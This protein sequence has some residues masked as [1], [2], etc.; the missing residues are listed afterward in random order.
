MINSF[1]G[2]KADINVAQ[3]NQI[4]SAKNEWF[5][6]L[7][8]DYDAMAKKA[9]VVPKIN[10]TGAYVLRLLSCAVCLPMTC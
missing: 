5:V 2:P 6:H 3:A 10:C 1:S 7:T 8:D 9:S 4:A